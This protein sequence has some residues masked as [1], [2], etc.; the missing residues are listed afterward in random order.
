MYFTNRY[1]YALHIF[2][3]RKI[4]VAAELIRGVDTG[5]D[6]GTA[7]VE[8][9]CRNITLKKR[10]SYRVSAEEKRGNWKKI[11]QQSAF[12]H[13]RTEEKRMDLTNK[14]INVIGDSITAGSGTSDIRNV[15]HAVLGRMVGARVVRNYGIGGTR[16]ARFDCPGEN[17]GPAFVDRYADMA[18]DA[19]PIL[20]FGGTNDYGTA[21]R[22]VRRGTPRRRPYMGRTSCC[23][24]G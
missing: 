8:D 4:A 23:C 5:D 11:H 12:R 19:D 7:F 10:D 1:T 14:T 17:W 22:W 16:V 6:P 18:E 3:K 9:D 15:Y 2:H 13:L 24:R 20:V 21:C